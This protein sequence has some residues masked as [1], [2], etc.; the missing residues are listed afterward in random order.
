MRAYANVRK[1]CGLLGRILQESPVLL[2]YRLSLFKR[3]RTFCVQ[4]SK[5]A[6]NVR[7]VSFKILSDQI[8]KFELGCQIA[9]DKWYAWWVAGHRTSIGRKDRPKD[10]RRDPAI[11][12]QPKVQKSHKNLIFCSAHAYWMCDYTVAA[13]G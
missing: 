7:D 6:L 5:I 2:A 8:F 9:G 12:A 11:S 1:V 13:H 10:H 3:S 4:A